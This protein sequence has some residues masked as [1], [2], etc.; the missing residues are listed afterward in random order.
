MRIRV[1]TP[2]KLAPWP[3]NPPTISWRLLITLTGAPSPKI[4]WE[5]TR[6]PIT[7]RRTLVSPPAYALI[8]SSVVFIICDIIKLEFKS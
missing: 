5:I 6:R 3:I 4:T 7:D 8:V 1:T 2:A